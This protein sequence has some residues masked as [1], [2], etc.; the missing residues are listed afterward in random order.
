[1]CNQFA[2]ELLFL[3]VFLS[4]L[5]YIYFFGSADGEESITRVQNRRVSWAVGP[6]VRATSPSPPPP[7]AS[8][9]RGGV[10]GNVIF[11]LEEERV[12]EEMK[13]ETGMEPL[14]EESVNVLTTMGYRSYSLPLDFPQFLCTLFSFVLIHFR[15]LFYMHIFRRFLSNTAK[16]MRKMHC[17]KIITILMT[18]SQ[19]F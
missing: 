1:M 10:S 2:Y 6:P 11:G 18:Q 16:R 5:L 14:L 17:F 12:W 9:L 3:L 7:P 19:L 4:F 13:V 8:S 15:F